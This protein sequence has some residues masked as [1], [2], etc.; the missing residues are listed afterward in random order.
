MN[1][2]KRQ[3]G[4]TM[5]EMLLTLSIMSLCAMLCTQIVSLM[6]AFPQDEYQG[7]DAAAIAQLQLLL[8]QAQAY[9]TDGT[10]L[11][12]LYHGEPFYLE[13][14]GAN[15]VKRKGYEI[16]LQAIDALQFTWQGTCI[17]LQYERED[18]AYEATIACE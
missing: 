8:A 17:V 4:F 12:F 6:V 2:Y 5:I 11:H 10:Q 15:L 18:K 7:E 3:Q 13:Q 14:H 16:Y 9:E 1:L